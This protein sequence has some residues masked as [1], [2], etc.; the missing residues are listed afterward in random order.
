LS[1]LG[2]TRISELRDGQVRTWIL[3][4]ASIGIPYARISDLRV[5]SVDEAATALRGVLEGDEGPRREIT[6]LNAAAALVIAGAADD[7]GG[8]VARAAAAI[9][10]GHA[11]KTLQSLIATSWLAPAS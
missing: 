6:L 10:S 7:L 2:P 4:P 11:A 8:G 1:T 9:D 3:D 5:S